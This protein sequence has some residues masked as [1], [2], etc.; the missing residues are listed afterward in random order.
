MLIA[1]L[2]KC[3]ERLWVSRSSSFSSVPVDSPA[4]I[5]AFLCENNKITCDAIHLILNVLTVTSLL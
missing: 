4:A 2:S 5:A 3:V 1:G